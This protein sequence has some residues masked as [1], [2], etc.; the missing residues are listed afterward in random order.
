[1]ADPEFYRAGPIDIVLGAEVVEQFM[2]ERKIQMTKSLRLR[3]STFGWVVIGS[4]NSSNTPS[5]TLQRFHVERDP[6]HL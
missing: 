4:I 5:K 1:M 6:S 3:D 2:L